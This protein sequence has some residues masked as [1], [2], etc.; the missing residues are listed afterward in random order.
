MERIEKA[1]KQLSNLYE[2]NRKLQTYKIPS[3]PN[4]KGQPSAAPDRENI[5]GADAASV[6]RGW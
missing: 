5:G 3:C 4:S 6:K 2:F 1:L